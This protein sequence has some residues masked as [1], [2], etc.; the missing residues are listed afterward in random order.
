EYV[1]AR[2]GRVVYERVNGRP[3]HRVR[4]KGHGPPESLAEWLLR[5]SNDITA[6]EALL[7]AAPDARDVIA[8]HAHQGAERMLKAGLVARHVP[9][10]R[11]HVLPELLRL[12][13]SD[14]RDDPALRSACEELDELWSSTRYPRNPMPTSEQVARAVACATRIRDAVR[15]AASI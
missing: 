8:F 2:E 1:G 11:S 13:S 4:E 15:A 10:P 9:P 3:A 5:A 14:L 7:I 6:M 12:S